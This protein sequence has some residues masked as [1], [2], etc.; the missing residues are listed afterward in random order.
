MTS[1]YKYNDLSL[2]GS[3]NILR[4]RIVSDMIAMNLFVVKYM[5]NKNLQFNISVILKIFPDKI[6]TNL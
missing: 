1:L 2:T 3:K 4:D 5:R 6:K